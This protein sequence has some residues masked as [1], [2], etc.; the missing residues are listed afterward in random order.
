MPLKGNYQFS[1]IHNWSCAA[2]GLSILSPSWILL[3]VAK[4]DSSN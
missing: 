4:T 2:T 1:D 3:M